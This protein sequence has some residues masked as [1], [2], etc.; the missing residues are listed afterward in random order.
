MD[1]PI[2]FGEKEKYWGLMVEGFDQHTVYGQNYHLKYYKDLF[3]NFG[4]Q[5]F[6]HQHVYCKD[7]KEPYPEKFY[8]RAERIKSRPHFSLDHMKN[9]DYKKYAQQFVEVYNAAWGTHHTFK[10]LKLEQA[11]KMFRKMKAIIDQRLIWFGYY[12]DTPICFFTIDRF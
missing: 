12:K 3:E 4:F 7:L 2:N 10:P 6:Y 5:V 8:E 11:E 9:H 1:G